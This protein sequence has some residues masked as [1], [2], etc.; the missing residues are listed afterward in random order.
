LNNNLYL[1]KIKLA[2]TQAY[3][4]SP[5]PHFNLQLLADQVKHH[6]DKYEPAEN[7]QRRYIHILLISVLVK[8]CR[9]RYEIAKAYSEHCCKAELEGVQLTPVFHLAEKEHTPDQID[10]N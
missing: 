2:I 6:R 7:I 3:F 8:K 9:S 4:S 5:P 10:W 1:Q